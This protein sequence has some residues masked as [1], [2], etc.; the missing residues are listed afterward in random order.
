MVRVQFETNITIVFDDSIINNRLTP[1]HGFSC[2]IELPQKAILFD[3]GGDSSILLNNMRRLYINPKEIDTV[4]LSH[5]HDDHIGGLI[6]FLEQN[7]AVTIYLLQS[8]PCN[9]KSNVRSLG[10]TV[11]EVEEPKEIF[12]NIY[13]TGQLGSNVKEQSLIINT[14]EGILIITGCAHPGMLKII[15]KSQYILSDKRVYLVM[16]GFHLSGTPSKMIRSTVDSVAELGVAKVAPC[17]CSGDKARRMF[18]KIYGEEY[19]EC[20]VGKTI[21]LS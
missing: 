19:I 21:T 2:L 8:F 11:V 14:I 7:K 5:I 4:V 20:G 12:S 17:H 9:F 13:T 16:G 3:T 15:K 1:G 18:K 10:A 6:G